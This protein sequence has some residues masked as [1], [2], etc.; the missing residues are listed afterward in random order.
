MHVDVSEDS[1]ATDCG[2]IRLSQR[3]LFHLIFERDKHLGIK[4]IA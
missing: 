1:S 2:V 4:Q 3:L